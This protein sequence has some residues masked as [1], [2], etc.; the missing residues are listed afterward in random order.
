M[1]SGQDNQPAVTTKRLLEAFRC[2]PGRHAGNARSRRRRP[3]HQCRRWRRRGTGPGASSEPDRGHGPSIRQFSVELTRPRV[4]V[5]PDCVL[6]MVEIR[7]ER[8]GRS[9]HNYAAHLL[10][11]ANGRITEW[12]MVDGAWVVREKE[13]ARYQ[14]RG[15]R[16]GL[17]PPRPVRRQVQRDGPRG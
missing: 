15:P 2:G 16:R 14:E 7:A 17:R 6:T 3:H 8:G 9:L 10:R 13:F 1:P 5:D 11:V 4:P 12:R